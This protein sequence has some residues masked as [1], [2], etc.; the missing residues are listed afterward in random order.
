MQLRIFVTA[1]LLTLNRNSVAKAISI[2]NQN[3][4]SCHTSFYL[5]KFYQN[6]SWET[7]TG[8]CGTESTGQQKV[9][10]AQFLQ[11]KNQ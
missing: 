4:L 7:E 8:G 11:K 3:S 9:Q 1:Y 5:C 6:P 2:K 10:L